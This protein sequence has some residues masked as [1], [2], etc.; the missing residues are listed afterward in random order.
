VTRVYDN[1]IIIHIKYNE[2]AGVK[3]LILSAFRTDSST[4]LRNVGK[5]LLDYIDY[6][7]C[8]SEESRLQAF[9]CITTGSDSGQL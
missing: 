4:I 5:L 8:V 3:V 1:N 9:V 7:A 6:V 2:C